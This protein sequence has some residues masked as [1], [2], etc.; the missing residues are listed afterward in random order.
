MFLIHKTTNSFQSFF[1]RIQLF[2]INIGLV[3][4][5]KLI[6]SFNLVVNMSVSFWSV[7][8]WF[9]WFTP[10]VLTSWPIWIIW[11][12][13]FFGIF[14]PVR[15]FGSFWLFRF[16]WL[17]RFFWLFRF[18]W[19]FGFIFARTW[20]FASFWYSPVAISI[21]LTNQML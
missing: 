19:F 8:P 9:I 13:G 15:F 11:F 16:L 1:N 3:I 10:A 2:K 7:S 18:V 6:L 14:W 20:T 17:F 5:F 21:N 12:I 4:T